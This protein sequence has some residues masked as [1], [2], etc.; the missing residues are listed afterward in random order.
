MEGR[1]YEA[2][3]PARDEVVVVRVKRIIHLG[4]YAALL[5]Y[6]GREGMMP[7]AEL[8]NFI[9]HPMSLKPASKLVRVGQTQLCKVL[10]VDTEKGYIDLSKRRV[11]PE[12]AAA[13]EE[14]YAHAKVVHGIMRHVA[15][16]NNIAVEELC[17]KISWPLRKQH[18]DAYEA[19][20][21]H[22]NNDI[23]LW[24]EIDFSQPGQDL[25]QKAEKL[26]AEIDLHARRRLLPQTIQLRTKIEVTCFEDEGVDAVRDSLLRGLEA[27]TADC[28]LNIS[29]VA[30]PLFALSCTCRDKTLGKQTMERAMDL[31]RSAI[32]ARGGSFD[33]ESLPVFIGNEQDP[34][35]QFGPPSSASISSN[36]STGCAQQY[37]GACLVGRD[38]GAS[39]QHNE[40]FSEQDM[41][42]S[43]RIQ[44]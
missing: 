32:Q 41:E 33:I 44:L 30:H 10:R 31:I 2:E 23:N 18:G 34:R 29:L 22:I 36:D 21:R 13:K 11:D 5:E 12:V 24:D 26:R 9:S 8:S 27:S 19:L 6:D 14:A 4:V 28:T 16:I 43:A 39:F 40:F 37:E 38:R 25:T 20:Q 17:K 1:F 42:E 15:S 35:L 3:F 7:V